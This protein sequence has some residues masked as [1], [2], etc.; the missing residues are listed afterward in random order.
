MFRYKS[1]KMKKRHSRKRV[2]SYFD[3]WNEGVTPRNTHPDTPTGVC[4]RKLMRQKLG[5][6]GREI[7]KQKSNH[8]VESDPEVGCVSYMPGVYKIPKVRMSK[9][10]DELANV[11]V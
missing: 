7:P 1:V 9:W 5:K 4:K 11:R 3:V 8:A 2:N 10:T 6:V